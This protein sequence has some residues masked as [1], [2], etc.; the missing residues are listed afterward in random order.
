MYTTNRQLIID[1]AAV[2]RDIDLLSDG[3]CDSPG[4]NTKNDAD[5]VLGKN[6]GLILDFN[7]SYVRVAGNLW[8]LQ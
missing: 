8:E 3:W 7:V 4:H 6:S 5:T 2:K 1:N